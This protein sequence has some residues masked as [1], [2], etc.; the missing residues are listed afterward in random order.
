MIWYG[1]YN[2]ILVLSLIGALLL[3]LASSNWAILMTVFALVIVVR[4]SATFINL[5][6]SAF[7]GFPLIYDTK[8]QMQ[9][10]QQLRGAGEV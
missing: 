9:Q 1:Q 3:S 7:T 6:F 2:A 8:I 4:I 5:M 10:A